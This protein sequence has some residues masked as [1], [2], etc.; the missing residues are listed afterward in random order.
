[1]ATYV[2]VVHTMPYPIVRLD[3]F[4]AAFTF[5]KAVQCKATIKNIAQRMKSSKSQ[6]NLYLLLANWLYHLHSPF[7]QHTVVLYGHKQ[8][9]TVGQQLQCCQKLQ[10]QSKLKILWEVFQLF[11]MKRALFLIN[12]KMGYKNTLLCLCTYKHNRKSQKENEFKGNYRLAQ[13]FQRFQKI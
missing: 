10:C 8:A 3:Y 9:L 5:V 13:F 6:L 11:F 2:V 12:E 1:M 4:S 7:A